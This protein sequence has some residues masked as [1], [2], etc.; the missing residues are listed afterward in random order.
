MK[1]TESKL[2]TMIREELQK[3]N[4]AANLTKVQ[5]VL[6]G[7]FV[8]GAKVETGGRLALDVETDVRFNV[9]SAE[10]KTGAPINIS[11]LEPILEGSTIEYAAAHR[12]KN[13][14]ELH[15]SNGYELMLQLSM[16]PDFYIR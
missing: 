7:S 5:D 4:E 1:L 3:L 10:R 12:S 6:H 16:N 2:R 14:L 8:A 11:E 13:A 15:V 9:E